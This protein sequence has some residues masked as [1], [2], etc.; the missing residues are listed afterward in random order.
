[1]TKSFYEI[2]FR[3]YSANRLQ[4]IAGEIKSKGKD[5]ILSV[6]LDEYAEYLYQTHL[7]EPTVVD[8][9]YVVGTPQK[10]KIRRYDHFGN[11][12]GVDAFKIPVKYNYTGTIDLWKCQPS[13]SYTMTSAAIDVTF[14][15]VT[16]YI[17]MIEQDA[18]KFNRERNNIYGSM[19]TN[20][21]G[22]NTDAQHWNSSLKNFIDS[23]LKSQYNGYRKENNFFEAIKANVNPNTQAIFTAPTIQKKPIPQPIAQNK[24]FKSEP[25]M[26]SKMY[27][28]VL[29]IIY[30]LGKSMEKK[31]STYLNK[32][33]EDLRDNFL[34]FLETRYNGTVGSAET[35][36]QSG[37]TDIILKYEGNT[38][39]FV[40][41]CKFWAGAKSLQKATDQLLGYLT[42]R[43]SKTALI[44]FVDNKNFSEVVSSA[45]V[46]IEKHPNFKSKKGIRGDTSFSYEFSLPGDGKS[47]F[48]ELILFHFPK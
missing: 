40:A 3:D 47:I 38:N 36:N 26:D 32:G 4:Q 33:E 20:M 29:K 24:E 34:L 25:S 45:T 44:I 43:D 5:Y 16:F 12:C 21:P 9:Q 13:N 48:I 11:Q 42:W 22:V 15:H 28:D 17:E 30:E 23:T 18:E 35:F 31:P 19:V 10:T 2:S 8:Q 7:L 39:L 14:S 27:D 1:M 46:S 6:N 37:K 41:E